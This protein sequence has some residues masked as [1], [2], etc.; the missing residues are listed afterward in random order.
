MNMIITTAPSCWGVDDVR[1]PHLPPWER[2]LDEAAQA[3]Y[4]GL[5]LGPYGYM[6]LAGEDVSEALRRRGLFVVAG[7]IFDDVLSPGN[8]DNLLRQTD[9][10]CGFITRLPKPERFPRQRHAAPYL[11]VMDW[12]HDERDF[13]AGHSDRAPRLGADGWAGMVANI[14]AVAERARDRHGVRAVLHPHA[15]GYIEFDPATETYSMTEEQAFALA[16]PDGGVYVPGAFVLAL[17]TLKAEP[18]ITEAVFGV[19]TVRASVASRTSFGGTA[20]ANVARMAAEWRERL[21]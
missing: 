10:I 13:A 6:P 18:R 7:T 8:R 9:E 1:N 21:A 11:T 19:L 20:P 15:G 2:V 5:E 14:R 16:N 12:G 17:G 4:G 3:G